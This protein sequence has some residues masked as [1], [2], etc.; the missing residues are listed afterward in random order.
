MQNQDNQTAL[1]RQSQLDDDEINLMDLLLVI[2]KHNRFILKL[3]GTVALLAVIYSL[4]LPNI[5]TAKTMI[6]PPQQGASMAGMLMGQLGGLASLAGAASGIKS[7]NDLYIG[8][9]K[10]VSVADALIKRFDLQKKYE[11]ETLEEVRKVLADSTEITSSKDGFITIEYSD[12]DPKFASS[13]ANAYVEELDKLN[14]VLAVTE[15]SRKR[16]F[17]ENQLKNTPEK[18]I[19]AE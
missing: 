14:N 5:Y 12:E 6:L 3:T 16:L 7:P 1:A 17:F 8:M 18:I 19:Y 9:L 2:A 11:A 15:S 13:M 4:M 10:S